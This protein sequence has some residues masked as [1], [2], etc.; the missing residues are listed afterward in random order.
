M[1]LS[2]EKKKRGR[3]PKK[4]DDMAEMVQAIG[5]Q[6]KSLWIRQSYQNEDISDNAVDA[7]GLLRTIQTIDKFIAL[8][9]KAAP[10]TQTEIKI[11]HK[12]IW[13]YL[14]K[15]LGMGR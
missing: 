7:A 15:K 11:N 1:E 8:Q 3:K 5:R 12:L 13:N 4:H 2:T 14:N 10:K 6:L 9:E